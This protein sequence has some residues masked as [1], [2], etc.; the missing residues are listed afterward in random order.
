M[1]WLSGQCIA[2]AGHEAQTVIRILK[3]SRCPLCEKIC[4]NV[5]FL[6]I[7]E[8]NPGTWKLN[9][10]CSFMN[11]PIISRNKLMWCSSP[12]D[13][14]MCAIMIADL[15]LVPIKTMQQYLPRSYT[16]ISRNPWR[17]FPPSMLTC[18]TSIHTAIMQVSCTREGNLI[19]I[20]L[21]GHHGMTVLCWSRR[22]PSDVLFTM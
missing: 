7:I 19:D 5:I 15:G 1:D 10:S 2:S 20:R 22:S 3:D 9:R 21:A 12:S 8:D 18:S 14:H 16:P 17:S 4:L 6:A 13:V 11:I